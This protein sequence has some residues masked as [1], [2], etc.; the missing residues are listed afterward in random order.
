VSNNPETINDSPEAVTTLPATINIE[1]HIISFS[2][3]L[4]WN[5]TDAKAALESVVERYVGLAVTDENLSDM[6][7]TQKEIASFRIKLD[8][9]RKEKK[10]QLSA[11][12]DDFETEIKKLLSIVDKAEAPLKDQIL[13][14]E[15]TRRQNCHNELLEWAKTTAKKLGLR[16]QNFAITIR[17]QWTNRGARESIVHKEIVDEID[18]LL[19]K[20]RQADE[21]AELKR[22]RFVLI[23]QLCDSNS[24]AFGL[25]TPVNC[26]DVAAAVEHA[27]L[28]ELSG[29]IAEE[30][31]KRRE[32]EL[33]AAAA[34]MPPAPPIP[35]VPERQTCNEWPDTVP[36][37]EYECSNDFPP[38]TPLPAVPPAPPP[39][40]TPTNFS[41]APSAPVPTEIWTVVLKL[42]QITFE[43]AQGFKQ[44]LASNNIKYEVVSQERVR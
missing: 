38:P 18:S 16:D 44:H 35:P 10:K 11:P 24:K 5:Y 30:C 43:Q 4:Q 37:Y 27:G 40:R 32:V 13:K 39:M 14:F 36:N 23:E 19:T 9:F 34:A 15:D 7:K 20:Q 25:S 6:E 2:Y 3:D 21:A 42:P 41:V 12:V 1:P 33:R 26:I 22:Q 17:Q 31:R 29:I 28:A 8:K